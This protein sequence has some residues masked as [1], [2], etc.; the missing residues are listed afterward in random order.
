MKRI[1]ILASALILTGCAGSRAPDH[2]FH[3]VMLKGTGKVLLEITRRE[4]VV[5]TGPDGFTGHRKMIYRAALVGN[6]PTFEN[7]QFGDNPPEYHCVGNIALDTEHDMVR[8]DMRR[9]VSKSGEPVVTKPH[10]ANGMYHIEK[11]KKAMP[12]DWWF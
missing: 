10:P 3:V 6:G 12:G 9:V 11:I 7:P 2:D 8:I 1:L 5:V 4:E